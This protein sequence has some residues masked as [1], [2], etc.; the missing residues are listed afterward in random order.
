MKHLGYVLSILSLASAS[1]SLPADAQDEPCQPQ[2]AAV[3]AASAAAEPIDEAYGNTLQQ[4]SNL[5]APAAQ[6]APELIGAETDLLGQLASIQVAAAL[7]RAGAQDSASA[8]A[9]S[10]AANAQIGVDLAQIQAGMVGPNG[11]PRPSVAQISNLALQAQDQAQAVSNVNQ[12]VAS[13]AEAL[14]ACAEAAAG[15]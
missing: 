2:A 12:N 9:A 13:A 8:D 6:E 5:I 15:A 11:S 3:E 14:A 10:A 1:F 7:Q 4:L